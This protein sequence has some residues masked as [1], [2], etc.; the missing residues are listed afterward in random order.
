MLSSEGLF[1]DVDTTGETLNKKIR[2]GETSQYN[3]ILGTLTAR[4]EMISI[5]ILRMYVI[6]VGQQEEESRS[7]N[8][9]NRDDVGTK[10]QGAM[11]ALD[12]VVK[13]LLNLKKTKSL[14]NKLE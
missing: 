1:A 12:E 13:K 2:N 3:F 11:E 14:E 6:V 8:V 5:I 9:R 7:V 10:K 4:L